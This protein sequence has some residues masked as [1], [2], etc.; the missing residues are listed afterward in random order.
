MTN[1][2]VLPIPAGA[3]GLD[4]TPVDDLEVDHDPCATA[5]LD[6]LLDEAFGPIGGAR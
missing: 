3:D 5:D 2:I 1:L 6:A 4:P